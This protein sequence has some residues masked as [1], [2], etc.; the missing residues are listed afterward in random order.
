LCT[1]KQ[2]VIAFSLR[3]ARSSCT[4][5]VWALPYLARRTNPYINPP[6]TKK[7]LIR[8]TR[9]TLLPFH[10]SGAT[11]ARHHPDLDLNRKVRFMPWEFEL[12]MQERPKGIDASC[13]ACSELKCRLGTGSLGSAACSGAEG[14][15]GRS[16]SWG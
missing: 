1:I 11:H 6:S 12:G 3:V 8:L 9:A 14:M 16:G 5:A 13:V 7:N 2:N 4:R 10:R 15:G